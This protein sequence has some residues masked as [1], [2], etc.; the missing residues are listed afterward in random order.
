[1]FLYACGTRP[2]C[3]QFDLWGC[4][5]QVGGVTSM[6]AAPLHDWSPSIKTLD[7]EAQV[8]CP[9]WQCFPVLPHIITGRIMHLPGYLELAPASPWASHHVPFLF[10]N[11]NLY[12]FL[13]ILWVLLANHYAWR[14]SWGRPT[15]LGKENTARKPR[16]AGAKFT[17]GKKKKKEEAIKDI[18]IIIYMAKKNAVSKLKNIFVEGY[19]RWRNTEF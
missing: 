12:P 15:Q 11:F 10:A 17:N 5:V 8:S 16:A 2:S 19:K 1:M 7:T 13:W 4:R 14:W 3:I 6:E 18:N 9:G